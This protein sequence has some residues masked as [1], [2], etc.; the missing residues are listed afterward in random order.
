MQNCKHSGETK[1]ENGYSAVNNLIMLM[2]FH[3]FVCVYNV[4]PIVIQ[5]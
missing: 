2:Y 4:P 1:T 3:D 5:N